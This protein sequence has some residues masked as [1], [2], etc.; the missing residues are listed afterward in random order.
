MFDFIEFATSRG[1]TGVNISLNGAGWRHLSAKSRDHVSSV[2]RRLQEH[3]MSLEIDTRG[4][5]PNHLQ[6]ML[7]LTRELGAHNVRAARPHFR[8]TTLTRIGA[9]RSR[10]L[11]PPNA[12]RICRLERIRIRLP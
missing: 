8:M 1:L 10:V 2:R 3:S 5:E 11:T 7:S 12:N 4:A 6:R 9:A